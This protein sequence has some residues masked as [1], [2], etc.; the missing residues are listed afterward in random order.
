MEA[1]A[2]PLAATCLA[3]V[4][5]HRGAFAQGLRRLEEASDLYHAAGRTAAA[6]AQ[7]IEL[8]WQALALGEPATARRH[9][10]IAVA[11]GAGAQAEVLEQVAAHRAGDRG[12]L[13]RAR[14]RVDALPEGSLRTM[15]EVVVAHAE[16]RW[17]EVVRLF[18]LG[19]VDGSRVEVTYLAADALERAG[20]HDDAARLFLALAEQPMSWIGPVAVGESW[21]RL[22]ALR[23]R[24]GDVPGAIAAYR[25]IVERWPRADREL[26]RLRHAQE[27]LRAQDGR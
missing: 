3:Y 6:R 12:A 24:A 9:L 18:R 8:A 16:E 2:E 14:A 7:R 25:K 13:A 27:R 15:L 5:L 22:G 23:E 26:P 10:A 1:V 19:A 21:D 20:R 17:D 4:E 11:S